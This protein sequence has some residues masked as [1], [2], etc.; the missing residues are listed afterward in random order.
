M[1]T[2]RVFSCVVGRGC[3]LWPVCSLGKTLLAFVLLQFVL[4][5][6]TCLLLQVSLDFLLL[7]SNYLWWKWHLFFFNVSSRRSSRH[8]LVILNGLP[9]KRTEII[10]SFL[11]WKLSTTFWIL[12]L[13]LT[14]CK[15]NAR[16]QSCCLRRLYKQLGKEEKWKAMEKGK[17]ISNWMQSSKE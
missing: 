6:Q 8:R 14:K 11:R 7:H 13:T 5:G 1:S 3:L 10:L 9:W 16:R 15:R 17:D 12:L 2:C 4:E